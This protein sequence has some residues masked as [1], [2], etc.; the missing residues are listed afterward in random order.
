ML[1]IH[2]NNTKIVQGGQQMVYPS[3]SSPSAS[4]IQK[5]N[6]SRNVQV[7]S[8]GFP[9]NSSSMSQASRSNFIQS[10]HTLKEQMPPQ[11]TPTQCFENLP[12]ENVGSSLK[13]IYINNNNNGNL[14]LNRTNKT[15][16]AP[17]DYSERLQK[18][19]R[20]IS[21]PINADDRVKYSFNFQPAPTGQ[22][23]QTLQVGS[24]LKATKIYNDNQ[25]IKAISSSS[26]FYY[27]PHVY[28]EAGNLR[29]KGVKNPSQ[30]QVSH[31]QHQQ[32]TA[33]PGVTQQSLTQG[34]H[35]QIRNNA[36]ASKC[37]V[38]R[39]ISPASHNVQQI[40]Y[41]CGPN[42]L[43]EAQIIY[44]DVVNLNSNQSG[45]LQS[46]LKVRTFLHHIETSHDETYAAPHIYAVAETQTN[47]DSIEASSHIATNSTIGENYMIVNGTKITEE[48]SARILHDLSQR[49]SKF[50]NNSMRSDALSFTQHSSHHSGYSRR[51]DHV[52]DSN[53]TTS[54]HNST[55]AMDGFNNKHINQQRATEQTYQTTQLPVY[56][57]YRSI[58]PSNSGNYH[59]PC[60]ER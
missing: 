5:L 44:N 9:G 13:T 26:S 58:N 11:L 45:V 15:I 7:L 38:Q 41:T 59:D 16:S 33:L 28:S 25:S 23:Q 19:S 47:Q 34:K 60:I 40:R 49:N 39:S 52:D 8:K 36:N 29:F 6:I 55:T 43:N 32:R 22:F 42:K 4:S 46:P 53:W 20:T 14:N 12:I 30:L 51:T 54:N 31:Q 18:G 17:V 35:F 21:S 2:G 24:N 10:H 57:N 48:M 50:G 1:N 27:Q 3:T 56:A 37:A